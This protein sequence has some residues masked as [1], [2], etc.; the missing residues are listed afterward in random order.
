M[1]ELKLYMNCLLFNIYTQKTNEFKKIIIKFLF[2]SYF[3]KNYLFISTLVFFKQ[4]VL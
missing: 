2:I 4:N 1:V 3:Q